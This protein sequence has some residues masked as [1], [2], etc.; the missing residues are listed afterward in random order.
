MVEG[1]PIRVSA[2]SIASVA[3]PSEVP[4]GKLNEMVDATNWDWWFTPSEVLVG[5]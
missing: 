1:T 4:S 2:S 5:A 3:C